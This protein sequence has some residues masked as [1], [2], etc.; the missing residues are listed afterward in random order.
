MSGEWFVAVLFARGGEG[1]GHW[2]LVLHGCT[3]CRYPLYYLGVLM[4]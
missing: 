1:M 2:D 3:E 4:L